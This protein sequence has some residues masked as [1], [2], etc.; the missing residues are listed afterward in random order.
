MRTSRVRKGRGGGEG[1]KRGRR[2]GRVVESGEGWMVWQKLN[3][4]G[5][6]G[7]ELLADHLDPVKA[8]FQVFLGQV[9]LGFVLSPRT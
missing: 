7:A 2:A 8:W 9:Y 3:G 5:P 6:Q 4:R 1:Q